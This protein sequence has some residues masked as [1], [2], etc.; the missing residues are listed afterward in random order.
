M[1]EFQRIQVERNNGLV[2]CVIII[3][4]FDKQKGSC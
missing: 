1:H 3:H 2:W 4:M